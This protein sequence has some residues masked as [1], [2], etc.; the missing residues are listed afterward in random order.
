MSGDIE[1]TM[2]GPQAY[3][4][5][6][7]AIELMEKHRVWP[8]PLNFELWSHFV[9][10][11]DGALA[12]ELN[13]LISAGEPMTENVSEE[14]AAA[15]LA[16]ARLNE[17]IRDAGDKLT[18]ELASVAKAI[19]TAQKST[20]AYGQTLAGASVDLGAATDPTTLKKMVET[21]ASATDRVQKQNTSLEQRLSDSTT[22]VARLREHLEQVRRDATTDGL[23]NLA[24]RKAFDEE[25][26]KACAD[27]DEQGGALT[28]A[29]LDI[30]HFK[31][32]ND[33]WGHQT[34][35]QVIRFV[36][37]VIGRVGATPR[38][39]ARY[40]GEEFAM[41]FPGEDAAIVEA[42]LEEIRE[43]VASRM[44]KRRSTNEDLGTITI[45]SGLA[46]RRPGETGSCT[47]ERADA[48]LYVSKR[49]GRN[50][51]TNGEQVAS[52]AA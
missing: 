27:A 49:S 14:L 35:D 12:K 26:A 8:T 34:G 10:D 29:V 16:K 38:F 44:L 32:F 48:A 2:R 6:R 39:A 42:C 36:A 31:N 11:P 24:N 22:E 40:G 28:L 15:Y 33:T 13:R 50:R 46:Q 7:K 1:Q 9:A 23:T 43:E 21:L 4:I 51:V 17:Q 52:V 18:Q 47:I 20:H 3:T 37:S 45:S 19:Q 30:D 41:I 25:L 5:V